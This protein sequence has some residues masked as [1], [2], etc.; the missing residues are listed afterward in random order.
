[1]NSILE[2][3]QAVKTLVG[4]LIIAVLWQPACHKAEGDTDLHHIHVWR[5]PGCIK[6]E[7]KKVR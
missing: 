6:A 1:M 4:E 7:I 5:E 3:K 2:E